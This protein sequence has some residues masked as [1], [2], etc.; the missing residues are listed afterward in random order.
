M[1]FACRAES[2]WYAK[3]AARLSAVARFRFE[4]SEFLFEGL[5]F[6]ISYIGVR[7]VPEVLG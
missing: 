1:L 3:A 2:L 7:M 4:G 5:G 6:R